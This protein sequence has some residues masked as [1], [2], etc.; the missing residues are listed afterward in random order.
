MPLPRFVELARNALLRGDVR[1]AQR[2]FDERVR[3]SPEDPSLVELHIVRLARTCGEDGA[4]RWLETTANASSDPAPLWFLQGVFLTEWQR[5]EESA[6]AYR[7]AVEADPAFADAWVNLGTAIDEIREAG[8][9]D[10]DLRPDPEEQTDRGLRLEQQGKEPSRPR[11]PR[12]VTRVL[13]ACACP[14][15]PRRGGVGATC[16]ALPGPS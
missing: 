2:V 4:I 8:G 9:G 15:A 16:S 5:M 10:C 14:G 13:P 12:G 11:P 6:D 1:W 3:E 7:R